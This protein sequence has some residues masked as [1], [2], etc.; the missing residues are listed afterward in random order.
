M[1]N[2]NTEFL[3][4][5]NLQARN[6]TGFFIILDIFLWGLSNERSEGNSVIKYNA[7]K[8]FYIIENSIATKNTESNSKDP[9]R[10][11]LI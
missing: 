1:R 6:E 10:L 8:R 9:G 4:K 5:T 7:D 3:T 2:K 11:W